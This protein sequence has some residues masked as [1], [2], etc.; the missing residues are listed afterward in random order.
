MHPSWSAVA[1]RPSFWTISR[2][3]LE[4]VATSRRRE[5]PPV[6]SGLTARVQRMTELC[7]GS[8]EAID[9]GKRAAD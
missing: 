8:P 4:S 7:F 2:V 9:W 5:I 1:T 6:A 3:K